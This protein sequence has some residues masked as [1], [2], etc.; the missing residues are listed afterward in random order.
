MTY[1]STIARQ[2]EALAD[3]LASVTTTLP[4]RTPG[5]LG[6]GV[7]AVT[8]IGASL[9]AARIGAAELRRLGRRA[10]ACAPGEVI[11]RPA[12]V[13]GLIGLSHRGRSV[14]TVEAF[15][16][17]GAGTTLA[18]TKDPES[19]LAKA[20]DIHV[21]MDNGEDATPSA[22]GYTCTLLAQAVLFEAMAGVRDTDWPRL[23]D[24]AATC[25]DDAADAMARLEAQFASRR[26]IDCV[27][28][29]EA[30][31]TA[32]EAALLLREAV[33]LP[34]CGF[35][36]RDYLHGPME[37][38]DGQT[39]VVVFGAAREV[40]LAGDLA[41]LGCPTL[42]VTGAQDVPAADLL[43]VIRVPAFAS[44]AAQALI[45]ILPAQLL[46]ATLSDAAGL[47]DVPFRYR[48]SDTKLA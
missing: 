43:T 22:T 6:D 10:L 28:G 12:L 16:A 21:H 15:D 5:T 26:A 45:D 7:I 19:P 17:L 46:A 32:V 31:G 34:A 9:A 42:L 23:I 24:A 37:P 13:D 27:A 18:I 2:P 1:R 38:M 25:L 41:A 4:D 11:A 44:V 35:E 30:A 20:A 40:Q 33:R 36:T 29:A 39:G 3:T 14:E 47:T 48:Q 8:G